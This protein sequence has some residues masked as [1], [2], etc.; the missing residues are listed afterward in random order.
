MPQPCPRGF[1]T[2]LSPVVGCARCSDPLARDHP[3]GLGL[4]VPVQ[5]FGQ[6][7]A[8]VFDVQDAAVAV[9]GG[10]GGCVEEQGA[11]QQDVA[12][13]GGAQELGLPFPPFLDLRGIESAGSMRTG[14]DAECAAR[15][16]GGIQVKP[17]S[18]H[19]LQP[20]VFTPI[21]AGP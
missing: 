10:A 19:L 3:S 1:V 21:T 18:Q 11:H 2:R 20:M 5:A 7:E 17:D 13:R 16:V 12:G 14:Q 8:G 15:G 6:G 9:G 4:I